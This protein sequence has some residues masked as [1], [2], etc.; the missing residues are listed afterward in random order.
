MARSSLS[1]VMISGSHHLND[2]SSFEL[3]DSNNETVIINSTVD[4][5]PKIE[6]RQSTENCLSGNYSTS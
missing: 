5:E 4:L 2:D 1:T 3:N 6:E